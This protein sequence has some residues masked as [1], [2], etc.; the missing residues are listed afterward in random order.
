MHASVQSFSLHLAFRYILHISHAN[1]S[2]LFEDASRSSILTLSLDTKLD[3][4][5]DDGGAVV[6]LSAKSI[7]F[8]LN[9]PSILISNIMC[10]LT[11]L[12]PGFILPFL[13]S[14]VV[15][16]S[17]FSNSIWKFVISFSVA[18]VQKLVPYRLSISYAS[19]TVLG[20]C[21]PNLCGV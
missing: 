18:L 20:A 21:I 4:V 2:K 12:Y 19:F 1:V 16:P 3:Y 9:F 17:S 11:C 5:I 8:I 15:T 6:W 7:T 10:T 14:S 13:I